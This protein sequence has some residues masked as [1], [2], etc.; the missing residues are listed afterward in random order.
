MVGMTGMHTCS[1]FKCVSSS[2]ITV[3]FRFVDNQGEQERFENEI[4]SFIIMVIISMRFHI[5]FE[6]TKN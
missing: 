2:Y 4:S 5:E 1:Y 3:N 6:I